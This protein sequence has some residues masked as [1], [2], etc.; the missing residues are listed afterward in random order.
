MP[1]FEVRKGQ[2]AYVT[3]AT[4]VEAATAQ[5]AQGLAADGGEWRP[6]GDI[7]EFDHEEI[8]EDGTA[9]EKDVDF[10]INWG[11][12]SKILDLIEKRAEA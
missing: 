1:F 2:D 8:Y 4:I 11:S 10:L 12:I 6:T 3:Y 7:S 9:Y 5:E